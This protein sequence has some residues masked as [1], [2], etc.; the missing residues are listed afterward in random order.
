MVEYH[1]VLWPMRGMRGCAVAVR[2]VNAIT[3]ATCQAAYVALYGIR[4][5]GVLSTG[6]E[7]M[8]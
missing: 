2:C 1:A 7:E 5:R 3:Y 6:A 4:Y 8:H